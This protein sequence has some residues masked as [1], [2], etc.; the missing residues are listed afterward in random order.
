MVALGVLGDEV[1]D[2]AE[3]D[4]VDDG[5]DVD[6]LVEGV[7]DP[8]AVHPAFEFVVEAGG[9]AFLDEEAGAGAADL[10]LVEPD[11]VDEAFDGAVEVGVVEDDVGG[12]AAEFEGE[13][14]AGACGGLAD[15]FADG[16][17]AG[18][19]DLVDGA[20]T[21]AAP[22]V[23]SPV[24]MLS[25][26]LGRPASREISAKRRAVR[27]V[28]SA[29]LRTTVFPAARAGATFQ[30]SIRRGKFQGMI[31]PQTPKRGEV[32]VFT[33]EELREAGVVGEVAGDEG[34]VDVAGFADR[35]AV[36]EGFQV[37]RRRECFWV[38]RAR[39]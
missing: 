27:G 7:A 19:G 11:G 24:T 34:D 21:S 4:R 30:A 33:R 36:V 8:E 9:D 5:A 22:V 10:A 35:F 13:G 25:T 18:E 12:F 16:G 6:G 28:Y 32:W 23:P 29:G 2:G 39:A 14:L 38:R 17:G 31:A 20:S 26:P 37:A 3:L 1:G 15:A